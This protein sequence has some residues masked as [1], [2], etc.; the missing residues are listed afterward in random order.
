M[1]GSD[2]KVKAGPGV[3]LG[4]PQAF[5]F[6]ETFNGASLRYEAPTPEGVRQLIDALRCTAGCAESPKPTEG[7]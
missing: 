1:S 7:K 5:V 6:V 3:D 4:A 2:F